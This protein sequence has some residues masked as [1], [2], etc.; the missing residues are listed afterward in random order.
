MET[1]AAEAEEASDPVVLRFV[2]EL[3][4]KVLRVELVLKRKVVI[5]TLILDQ[6]ERKGEK[7]FFFYE[8]FVRSISIDFAPRE[9]KENSD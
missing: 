4:S 6:F 9:K 2:V 1:G 7:R 5:K 8:H 3:D